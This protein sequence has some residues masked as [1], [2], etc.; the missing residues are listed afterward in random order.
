MMIQNRPTMM[1]KNSQTTPSLQNMHR[2]NHHERGAPKD[3]PIFRGQE[4]TRNLREAGVNENVR[5]DL[6][7]QR[8]TNS[9]NV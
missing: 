3:M 5:G 9:K 4:I 6:S 7:P 8:G 1:M 2:L